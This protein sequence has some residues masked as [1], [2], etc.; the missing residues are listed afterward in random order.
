MVIKLW[1]AS[2]NNN[3]ATIL[4]GGW[5]TGRVGG[6]LE[7]NGGDDSIV[8]IPLSSSLRTTTDEITVMAWAYRTALHNSA[9]LSQTYPSVF[10]GFHFPRQ[11]KWA[12][13]NN[14]GQTAE[15]YADKDLYK[16]N[17]NTW[18]HMVGTY[19]STTLRLYVNGEEICTIDLEGPRQLLEAPM[20]ISGY[21][22]SPEPI[23]DEITG[24]LDEVR[25][26]N[27]ALT[28]QEIKDIYESF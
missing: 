28:I 19:D 3:T 25:I 15:C 21:R 27:K 8:E 14:I 22:N 6:A 5:G 1:T 26:Y 7:M 11:F 9:I 12:L 13:T 10:F 17:L 20:T 16:A 23:I 4:N 24:K 2:G 18:Y